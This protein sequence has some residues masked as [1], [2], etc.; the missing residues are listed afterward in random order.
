MGGFVGHMELDVVMANETNLHKM[1]GKCRFVGDCVARRKN[2]KSIIR[3][4]GRT[5]ADI[6]DVR[7]A[8]KYI[9]NNSQRGKNHT[10][11]NGSKCT[12]NM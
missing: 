4:V 9:E 12:Q 10:I 6:I 5:M 11:K 1:P 8:I 2:L 7:R 3:T